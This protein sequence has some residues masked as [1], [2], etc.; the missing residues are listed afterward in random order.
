MLVGVSFSKMLPEGLV[1]VP[2]S[3]QRKM[4]EILKEKKTKIKL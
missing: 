4:S 1:S 3:S 2:Q